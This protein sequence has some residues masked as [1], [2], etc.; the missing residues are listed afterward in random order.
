[1]DSLK[2]A[3]DCSGAFFEFLYVFALAFMNCTHCSSFVYRPT[4]LIR[5]T[6]PRMFINVIRL[7]DDSICG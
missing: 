6:A 7:E 1:M 3:E 5:T 4:V 2:R